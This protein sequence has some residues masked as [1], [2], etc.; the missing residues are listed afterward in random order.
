MPD[1]GRQA[2][3]FLQRLARVLPQ[4]RRSGRARTPDAA[5]R[6]PAPVRSPTLRRQCSGCAAWR[7]RTSSC[8]RWSPAHDQPDKSGVTVGAR[9]CTTQWDKIQTRA[10]LQAIAGS[11]RHGNMLSTGGIFGSSCLADGPT[12]QHP[13]RVEDSAR[14]RICSFL[15]ATLPLYARIRPRN[16]GTLQGPCWTTS[17]LRP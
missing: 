16:G 11:C 15:F 14:L 13:C 9:S 10:V 17:R 12:L 3:G 6:A 8:A 2:A 5:A 4:L 7:W 1:A